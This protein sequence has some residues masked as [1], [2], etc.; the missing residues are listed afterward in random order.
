MAFSL[1]KNTNHGWD[2]N[3]TLKCIVIS[4]NFS[5]QKNIFSYVYGMSINQKVFDKRY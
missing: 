2:E 1:V 3:P 4:M 5:T